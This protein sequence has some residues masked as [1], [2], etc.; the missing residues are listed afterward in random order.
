MVECGFRSVLSA[1]RRTVIFTLYSSVMVVLNMNGEPRATAHARARSVA[2]P[3]T[4]W[5]TANDALI[6]APFLDLPYIIVISIVSF[7]IKKISRRFCASFAIER[8][9]VNVVQFNDIY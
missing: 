4:S 3:D 6:P 8:S 2:L 7:R 1:S 5:W 9:R